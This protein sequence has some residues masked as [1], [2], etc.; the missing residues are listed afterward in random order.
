V[1]RARRKEGSLVSC[2]EVLSAL[3]WCKRRRNA[4]YL[5]AAQTPFGMDAMYRANTLLSGA[6]SGICAM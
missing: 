2:T 1:A 3:R 6:A 4:E 5:V